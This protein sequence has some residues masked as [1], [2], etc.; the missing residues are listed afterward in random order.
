MKKFSFVITLLFLG[1]I[2][3]AQSSMLAGIRLFD[4]KRQAMANVPIKLIETTSK[5]ELTE[6]TNAQGIVTFK[7]EGGKEW[8]IHFKGVVHRS[9]I[10]MPKRVGARGKTKL[11]LTYNPK[12]YKE[13]IVVD[14][15]KIT[16]QEINQ[17]RGNYSRPKRGMA[18]VQVKLVGKDGHTFGNDLPVALVQAQIKKKFL[19]RTD[20]YGQAI[21]MVPHGYDYVLDINKT[22]NHSSFT[23]PQREGLTL[24]QRILYEATRI[25]EKSTNDTIIQKLKRNQGGTSERVLVKVYV[26]NRGE[27]E[28]VFL[29]QV[30]GSTVYRAKTNDQGFAHFLLPKEKKYMVHFDFQRDVDVVDLVNMWGIGSVELRLNY[31]PDPRLEYP[32]S[33]LPTPEQLVVNEF[34]NFLTRQLEPPKGKNNIG[35]T[36]RWGN[37]VNKKS[38][39]AVLNVGFSIKNAEQLAIASPAINVAFVMDKSGS[40]AGYDRIESLQRSLLQFVDKLRPNDIVSLVAFNDESKL[41]IPA[42]KKGN[43][44]LLK[45][46]IGKLIAGG[47][48]VIFDGMVMGYQELEKNYNTKGTNRLVLLTDGYG[49]VRIDSVVNKS[50]EYNAKGLELSAIGVGKN[51]NQALLQLLATEG[52]GLLQHTGSASGVDEV[53]VNELESVLRPIAKSASFEIEYNKR[54]VLKQLF[55][56]PVENNARGKASLKLNNLYAG[57]NR[58]AILKFD[59]H[60]PS[61]SITKEPVVLR[62]RYFDI[63]TQKEVV[64]EKKAFL[65][66]SKYKGKLELVRETEEKK[67]YAIAT[68]N[69]TLKA[70]A[71]ANARK[72]FK[73]ATK[74]LE[75]TRQQMKKIFPKIEDQDLKRLFD[76]IE[77]YTAAYKKVAQSQAKKA[78]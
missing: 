67:L 77:R 16:L 65:K 27:G 23:V 10:R 51:Y 74:I 54:I 29:H 42:Q 57:L 61:S 4:T 43:G 47:G 64:I 75:S 9:K 31:H 36:F 28:D 46:N 2:L 19:N 24:S 15:N 5:A 14:R 63:A 59:L 18:I 50:K 56:F 37:R 66:W 44:V 34:N 3:M 20:S 78:D 58:L 26:K 6:T 32:E 39:E 41:L 13:K 68:I 60:K 55:G 62:L 76:E 22:K 53:F 33:F 48:T 17:S 45:Q 49:T 70:M 72:D 38:K 40:M 52:G 12:H 21:F 25:K 8:E 71:E 69:Q 73:T 35:F 1:Q 7:I 11:T 30:K